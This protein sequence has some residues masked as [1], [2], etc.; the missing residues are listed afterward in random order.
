[1]DIMSSEGK[2]KKSHIDNKEGSVLYM[3]YTLRETMRMWADQYDWSVFRKVKD[4]VE[5]GITLGCLLDFWLLII[6]KM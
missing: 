4:A 5:I 2:A 6:I 1:M 3:P